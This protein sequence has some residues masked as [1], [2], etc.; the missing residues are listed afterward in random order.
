MKSIKNKLSLATCTL[1][2]GGAQ[3]AFAIDNAWDLDSSFLYYSE[4]N[5][6]VTVGKAIAHLKGDLSDND[7][8]T[9]GLVL[10]TISGSTPTGAIRSSN[11]AITFTSASGA[12]GISAEG[13]VPD[14]VKFS[15]ARLAFNLDWEHTASR[16][17]K[18]KYGGSLSVENDYQSYGANI[19]M[20]Q[21]TE[22]RDTTYTYGFAYSLDKIYRKNGGTPEPMSETVDNIV[23]S[24]GERFIYDGIVGISKVLN[25]RTVGQL[26][27]SLGYSDGYHSDPYK[28]VSQADVVSLSDPSIGEYSY[29]EITRYY[30]SRPTSRLRS[31]VYTSMA[32]QYGER[33][34]LIHASYRLYGDDWGIIAHT[35]D[36]THRR[37]LGKGSFL[38]PHF[39]FHIQSAADFFMHHIPNDGSPLPEFAS[40]DYRLDSLT[41]VTVGIQY[42]RILGN[43]GKLRVRFEYLNQQA[44]E[45][46]YDENTAIVAQVSY[47]KL[48]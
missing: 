17:R 38:Q 47:R 11:S 3:Q 43:N 27:F 33:D 29:S 35:F 20:T 22:N 4:A 21:D 24:D 44:K 14:I 36:L 9:I 8:A 23:L 30:E 6:R 2:S 37:P 48:F 26:N 12:N 5:D 42:G 32:H 40:A 19:S 16:L 28:V 7:T 39:R 34:E 45:A 31:S 46:E 41:S 10:D 18:F 13:T 1:L 15:D 25:K